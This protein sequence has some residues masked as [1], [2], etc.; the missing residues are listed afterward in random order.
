MPIP[1]VQTSDRVRP[2]PWQRF[3]CREDPFRTG[4]DDRFVYVNPAWEKLLD[5]LHRGFA[6]PQGIALITG[7]AGVGK[8][9]LLRMA[10][11]K[12][13][14][15]NPF[16]LF[17]TIPVQSLDA[18]FRI[19]CEQAGMLDER[20]LTGTDP[21]AAFRGLI[22]KL[23]PKRARLL[24]I[25]EAQAL[26][27][28]VLDA[29]LTLAKPE[30]DGS[31]L[32]P[33]ILAGERSLVQRLT[34]AQFREQAR[35]IGYRRELSALDR[36]EIATF[37]HHRLLSAG[38]AEGARFTPDAIERIADYSDGIPGTITSLCRLALFFSAE[39]NESRVTADAVELATAATLFNRDASAPPSSDPPTEP[40]AEPAN[41]AFADQRPERGTG[42]TVI[43][44]PL[45]AARLH[46]PSPAPAAILG[47]EP[48]E[49][50]Q[51]DGGHQGRPSGDARRPPP[52]PSRRRRRALASAGIAVAA[53]LGGTALV[54]LLGEGR[55]RPSPTSI[56]WLDA[57]TDK[58]PLVSDA[59]IPN[60]V[61]SPLTPEKKSLPAKAAQSV[62]LQD[63]EGD[64]EPAAGLR[65]E[66]HVHLAENR[67]LP[68]QV[69]DS[70]DTVADADAVA[71]A[72]GPSLD[73]DA[74]L[75]PR[76][77]APFAHERDYS[78]LVDLLQIDDTPLPAAEINRLLALAEEHFIADRLMAPRFDNAFALYRKVLRADP[79]HSAAL[80][81][82][83]AI[84]SK[85][86][87]YAH[88]EAAK[89]NTASARRQLDK[90]QIIDA[91]GQ[92]GQ[93]EPRNP[94]TL[95]DDPSPPK[96]GPAPQTP[97]IHPRI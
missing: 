47:A 61:P 35:S 74:A 67:S 68:A 10:V 94:A 38:C 44:H 24:V 32:L 89:G 84:R 41:G 29:L 86:I 16:V 79:E 28:D 88:S 2:A 82:I 90:I 59:P 39:Q 19:G 91:E 85:L 56:H 65:P 51:T 57:V 5:R 13:H 40:Q 20:L 14:P 7:P 46:T 53:I 43:G 15:E 12:L 97:T 9:T 87:E 75:F 69:S 73:V 72:D 4:F 21:S 36:P 22:S 42:E 64:A 96:L 17:C 26:S 11:A 77:G 34:Q 48:V 25:D 71:L 8:T 50:A 66:P 70:A 76:Q 31:S 78:G 95:G 6:A 93:S 52:G 83:A 80:A 60:P 54:Q 58:E 49:R 27:D 63:H 1:S 92:A 30:R 3:D 18:L 81:G 62:A 55:W 33:I 37:I 45:D 23:E